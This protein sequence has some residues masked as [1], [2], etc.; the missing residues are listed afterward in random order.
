MKMTAAKT[1]I[2][3]STAPMEILANV[4]IARAQARASAKISYRTFQT[5]VPPTLIARMVSFVWGILPLP[6]MRITARIPKTVLQTLEIGMI[7]GFGLLNQA[8]EC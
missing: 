6:A 7:S 2:A 3:T 8:H 1:M 4:H 5:R